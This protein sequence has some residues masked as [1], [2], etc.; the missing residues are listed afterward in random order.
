MTARAWVETRS[1]IQ[2]Y[3][4]TVKFAWILSGIIDSLQAKKSDE[5]LARSL[6]GLA[7]IK[8]LSLDKGSWTL[9]EP[10]LLEEPAPMASFSGG[11]YLRTAASY[12]SLVF[13]TAGR[14]MH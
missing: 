10:M 1:R 13:S 9:A 4:S 11:N 2:A 3:P 12:R 5:A 6:V 8:Q 14:W 7:A